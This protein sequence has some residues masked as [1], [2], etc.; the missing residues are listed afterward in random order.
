MQKEF[1]EI[2]EASK[3]AI[4][5]AE[6]KIEEASGN[7]TEEVS[8]VWSELKTRF[9]AVN[10]KLKESYSDLEANAELKAYLGMMEARDRLE[11]VKESAEK[12]AFHVSKKT[13]EELDIAALK[14]H[15]AKMESEE[16]LEEKQKEFS[17]LY[18]TSKV[19]AQK[20]SKKALEE[21]NDIFLKLT[22]VV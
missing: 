14:A 7:F 18:A 16:L 10:G 5:N 15:L 17:R 8:D 1:K 2:I 19:E 4:D 12:F 22:E 6:K 20:L 3:K 13:E 11:E 9:S 21:I